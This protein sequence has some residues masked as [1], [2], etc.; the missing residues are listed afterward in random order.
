[1]NFR[2]YLVDILAKSLITWTD[3][4]D[5]KKSGKNNEMHE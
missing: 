2:N 5:L 4:E 1:M 3:E